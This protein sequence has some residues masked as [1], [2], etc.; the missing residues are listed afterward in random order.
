MDGWTAAAMCNKTVPIYVTALGS[1]DVFGA[2][3]SREFDRHISMSLF[4]WLYS[5]WFRPY[6]SNVE[7]G[8]FIAYPIHPAH[9]AL[10]LEPNAMAQD[11][12]SMH[13]AICSQVDSLEGK[14]IPKYSRI[15]YCNSRVYALHHSFE[16]SSSYSLPTL[17]PLQSRFWCNARLLQLDYCP[18]DLQGREHHGIVNC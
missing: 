9:V 15:P 7:F 13:K 12:V 14:P 3:P 5:R 2:Q 10:D 16:H 6:R 4:F 11:I 8:R 17:Q 1:K 18:P